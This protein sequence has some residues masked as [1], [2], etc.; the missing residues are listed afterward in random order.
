MG[1]DGPAARAGL[2]VGDILVSVGG[3]PV[4]S[5]DALRGLLGPGQ[6]GSRL[7]VWVLRGGTRQELSVEVGE[8]RWEARC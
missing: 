6:I 7:R 5:L 1:D 2:L 8:Q 4:P 3:T